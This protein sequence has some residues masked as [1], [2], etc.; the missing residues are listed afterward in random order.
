MNQLTKE[1][2]ESLQEAYDFVVRQQAHE[3]KCLNAEEL[4]KEEARVRSQVGSI[5]TGRVV[6]DMKEFNL[7]KAA[8][9]LRT[10]RA[11]TK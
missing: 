3:G 4:E 5:A 11:T 9:V 2:A 10:Y 1:L 6:W 8:K 7:F